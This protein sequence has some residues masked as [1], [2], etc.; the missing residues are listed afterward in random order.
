MGCT[1]KNRDGFPESLNG[2][3]WLL[4]SNVTELRRTLDRWL[5]EFETP[6]R[7]VAEF[8][9]SALMK[10]FGIRSC[11][12]FPMPSAVLP[13]VQRTYGMELVGR[14]PDLRVRYFVVT[15]E[16]KL[17]HPA[18]LVI[19]QTAKAGLLSEVAS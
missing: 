8:D 11:G 13:E 17:A 15:T 10:E 2:A 14:L 1:Q 6:P 3:P 12:L 5:D 9:D 4:P 16:R 19:A 7:V 18:M